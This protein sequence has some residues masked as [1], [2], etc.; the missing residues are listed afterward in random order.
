[1]SNNFDAAKVQQDINAQTQITQTF[2]TY[3][4]KA[5]GDYAQTQLDQARSLKVQADQLSA[6]PQ[7][8]ERAQQLRAQAA[9]IEDQWGEGGSYRVALHTATGG[10]S[11]G[12]SGA[13]GGAATASAAPLL[14]DLQ[15]SLSQSLK[16]AGVSE[17]AANGIAKG[18]TTVT[19]AGI[20]ASVGMASGHGL[21]GAATAVNV[22]ANNRQL[23]FEEKTLIAR[24]A[25]GDKKSEERLKRA[26]CY[27]VKCWRQFPEGSPL[28]QQNYVSE[29]E[30]AELTQEVIWVNQQKASGAFV[31]TPFQQ[32]T[33]DVA[34]TTGISSVDG[35]GTFK[36]QFISKP[37]PPFRSNDCVTA[38]CA[39]GMAPFRGYTPPDYISGQFNFYVAN[40]T[41]AVNLHNG[42]VYGGIGF[43]RSYPSYSTKPGISIT[44][45]SIF[46]DKSAQATS[47]FLSGGGA[48]TGAFSPL[49][50]APWLGVGGGVNHSYGGATAV[51]GGVSMP[52]GYAVSPA[53]YSTELK[54]GD[55]K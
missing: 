15:A 10:L 43:G 11:G 47:N 30:A 27:E 24:K 21:A 46:G 49:P 39:A 7:D 35:K 14:N 26:A 41:I 22:D 55:K 53:G 45:G 28:Y 13:L 33:D 29:A 23:H 1:M 32:F 3:A 19:A 37:N 50:F 36:G 4:A 2:G 8:Q 31:Y 25:D 17:T 44:A 54:K 38:E 51:E 52:P 12:L 16:D 40:G 9:Q 20:G 34:A 6:D 5:V 48:Q 18:I 42:D